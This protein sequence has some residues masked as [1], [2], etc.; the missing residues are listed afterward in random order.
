MTREHR[1]YI[2][3]IF[4]RLSWTLDLMLLVLTVQNRAQIHRKPTGD[5]VPKEGPP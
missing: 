2:G 5:L 1:K 3:H 4:W